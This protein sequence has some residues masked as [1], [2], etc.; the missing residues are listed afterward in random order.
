[1]KK[2]VRKELCM[3]LRELE[4]Y[5]PSRFF[6]E[7]N[8]ATEIDEAKSAF[9]YIDGITVYTGNQIKRE[10][11]KNVAINE[12]VREIGYQSDDTLADKRARLLIYLLKNKIIENR[13]RNKY[14]IS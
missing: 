3:E 10:L 5:K 13:F 4:W 8:G 6:Y 2:F 11:P 14:F 7:W 9:W 12:N 1:M